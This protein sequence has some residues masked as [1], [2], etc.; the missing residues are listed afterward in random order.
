M[1]EKACLDVQSTQNDGPQTIGFGI[2]ATMLGTLELQGAYFTQQE[3]SLLS[4]HLNVLSK[5]WSKSLQKR[6][7]E[8]VSGIRKGCLIA[9]HQQA[10][11]ERAQVPC[12]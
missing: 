12:N 7:L 4:G 9:E 8:S 11:P 1:A 6:R 5:L 10:S 3:A 2:K